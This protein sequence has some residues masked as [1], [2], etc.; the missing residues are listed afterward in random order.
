MRGWLFDSICIE[1]ER[2][3]ASMT[4]WCCVNELRRETDRHIAVIIPDL[5]EG[6]W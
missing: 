4:L 6:R 5:V 1:T 2:D 3:S